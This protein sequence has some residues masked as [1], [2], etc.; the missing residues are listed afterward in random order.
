MDENDTTEI[1]AKDNCKEKQY[2]KPKNPQLQY[3]QILY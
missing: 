1:H 2:L 3:I